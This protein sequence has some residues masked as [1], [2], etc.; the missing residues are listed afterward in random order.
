[1][2][3]LTIHT[4]LIVCPLVFL[5][6]F[7]D[8]IGGGGGLISLP[9]YMIS[10]LPPH[11]AIATNKL[12]SSVG[13]AV[14][15]IR[16]CKNKFVNWP[17]AIPSIIMA[18]LGSTI[19]ANLALMVEEKVMKYILL[20]VL[21]IVAFY[22]LKGKSFAVQT[23]PNKRLCKKE[24]VIAIIASFIIGTYDGFYG[25]GTGTFL[26][27]IYTG[28]SKMDIRIASGNTK[29][30]NL[31]SNVAALVT[32]LLN[33]KILFLLGATAAIFSIA[34]NYLGSGLVLKNGS[35]IIRPIILVVLVLLFL[36]MITD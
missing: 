9:A 30:V 17:I 2:E 29:L 4:F 33:G 10:G 19:G 36:K 13:T 12:S 3:Q 31:S 24:V 26:I 16:Y 21:P 6:G 23:D 15:T 11:F 1:M 22:V 18:L 32:F 20:L 5:A 14:S 8:S 34:G 35:K 27:L 7:V 25:P 28:L